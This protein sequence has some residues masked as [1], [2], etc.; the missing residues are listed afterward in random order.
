MA[1]RIDGLGHS[2]VEGNFELDQAVLEGLHH[3]Y[4]VVIWPAC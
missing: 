3:F 4:I 1:V 2:L